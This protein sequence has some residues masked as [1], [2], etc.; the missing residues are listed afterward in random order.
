MIETIVSACGSNVGKTRKN[1]EDNFYYL[2][3]TLPETNNGLGSF[4]YSSKTKLALSLLFAVMDGMG[5]EEAGEKASFIAARTA[6]DCVSEVETTLFSP[7]EFLTSMCQRMNHSVCEESKKL[8]YGTMGSTLASL[9]FFSE[10]VYACNVGDSKIFRLRD[11]ELLQ[12]SEDH[13]E[14]LPEGITRKPRL[15]QHLGMPEDEIQIEPF[16]AKGKLL[17]GDKYLICS[18]G[19][20]DM[21][22]NLEIHFILNSCIS[23]QS[24]AK[25]LIQ[26]AL[27]NGG[28]DNCTVIVCAVE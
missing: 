19:L 5:G 26:K 18:D 25:K 20:T 2:G 1:N 4:V 14:Q 16:I 17:A 6:A 12:L 3:K 27:K 28:K 7:R 13:T 9:M 23:V 10:E 11:N 21:L 15:T 8:P 24:C 22:T